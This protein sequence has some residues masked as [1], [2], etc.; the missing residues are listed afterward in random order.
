M[1]EAIP[2]VV[3]SSGGKDSLY[4]LETLRRDPAWRVEALVTTVNETNRRVAM[5]GTSEALLEAQAMSLGLPLTVIGLPEACDNREYERRLARGLAAHR[6]AGVDHIACGDLFLDDIRRWREQ[7]FQRMGWRPVFPIWQTAPDRLA[8][9]LL[10]DQ[11]RIV[12]TCID[13]EVLPESLLGKDIDADLLNRLPAGI[14]P[15]GENGEF[16]TFVCDGPGFDVPIDVVPGERVL[17]HER[18]LM[19]E[20]E[21]R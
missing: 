3:L 14:D 1:S 16:H 20:L 12:I 6:E 5:H 10:D 21:V 9:Q 17:A 13:T 7:S 18:Y 19:V 4:M 15:C 2:I 8:Q 11:W